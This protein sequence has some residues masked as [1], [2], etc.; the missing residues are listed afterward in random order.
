MLRVFHAGMAV[1]ALNSHG[2]DVM[3]MAE[4][5]GLLTDVV[6]PR[7]IAGVCN[8]LEKGAAEDACNHHGQ[9]DA[10]PGRCVRTWLKDL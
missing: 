2:T 5:N 7:R 8:Q 3:S 9:D 6:L 4:R 10:H 1:A